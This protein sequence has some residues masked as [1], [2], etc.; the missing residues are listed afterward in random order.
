MRGSGERTDPERHPP[1][2][3]P[4]PAVAVPVASLRPGDS[5][6]LAG[7]D[8]EHV[9][10]LAALPGLPPVLVHRRTMRVVDGMHRLHAARLRGDT[11]IPAVF[12]DGDET[13]AFLRAVERN[14][15][16]GLPL[17][18]HD[19]EA[20][21]VRVL[22]AHRR[23]SDRAVAAATGL[24]PTTVGA[25]RRRSFAPSERDGGGARAADGADA[26][27]LG[28]D[29]RV[30][31]LDA[32]A[33]RLRASR[34]IA[35]HPEASLRAI[36]RAAGVSVG[37]AHDVRERLRTGRDPLP[38]R[39]GRA[40]GAGPGGTRCGTAWAGTRPCGTRRA[41]GPS[42]PGP[43]STC[44][45]RTTWPDGSTRCRRTGAA[46]WPRWPGRAPRRGWS[47]GGCWSG[48]R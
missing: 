22:A 26:G 33:G 23:W 31:P 21:A 17:S 3:T 25:I 47:S 1:A 36:A 29:G 48:G 9:R 43:T 28:R 14:L 4:A 16:G 32:S 11:T 2:R 42:W 45:N 40:A 8:P 34:V 35:R 38:P 39:P 44:W 20:A 27:R 46:R 15:T 13:A 5:P 37:T 30:R 12:F 24:S 7:I 6:R 10:L 19:R 41:A 18:L